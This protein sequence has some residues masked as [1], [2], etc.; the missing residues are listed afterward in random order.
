MVTAGGLSNLADPL[1]YVGDAVNIRLQALED[2]A[3]YAIASGTIDVWN[4]SDTKVVTAQAVAVAGTRATYQIPTSANVT[5][6]VH[7]VEVQLTYANSLGPLTFHKT[8][9]LLAVYP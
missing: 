3:P 8:Y 1:Y 2:G 7:K 6:G 5:A 9:T 4:P